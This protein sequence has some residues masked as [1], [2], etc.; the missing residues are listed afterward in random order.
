MQG[1][2]SGLIFAMSV[3]N[4][5]HILGYV[6][7]PLV[8]NSRG[9]A[10]ALEPAGAAASPQQGDVTDSVRVQAGKHTRFLNKGR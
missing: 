6:M 5:P 9:A 8:A 7:E 10:S 1:W 3:Q 2:L 4:N